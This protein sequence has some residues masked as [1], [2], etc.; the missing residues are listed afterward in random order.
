MCFERKIKMKYETS[1]QCS[2]YFHL[3]FIF[4]AHRTQLSQF[5]ILLRLLM[6]ALY[7]DKVPETPVTG[8]IERKRQS[9]LPS[10]LAQRLQK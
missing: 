7:F 3:D 10:G 2:R 4:K 6:C 9:Y 5:I 8:L 1:H